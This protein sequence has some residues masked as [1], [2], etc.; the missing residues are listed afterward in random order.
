MANHKG[1]LGLPRLTDLGPLVQGEPRFS[2]EIESQSAMLE[3]ISQVADE[4]DIDPD[5]P[6]PGELDTIRNEIARQTFPDSDRK[7]ARLI[8]CMN[9]QAGEAYSAGAGTAAFDEIEDN[10]LERMVRTA[11]WC[12]GNTES[13]TIG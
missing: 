13:S 1:V 10:P 3:T 8:D 11:M 12:A 2:Q 5:N 9:S 7:Q 4:N 6:T